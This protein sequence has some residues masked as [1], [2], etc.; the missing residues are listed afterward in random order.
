MSKRN[1]EGGED[2]SLFPFLSVLA[3]VIGTLTMI[4]AAIAVQAL[5]N[6]T[7]E[8]AIEYQQKEEA[9]KEQNLELEKLRSELKKK[10]AEIKATQSEE[11]KR[12]QDAKKRLAE[13]LAQLEKTQAELQNI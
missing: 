5:D 8:T 10:E 2:I 9:L 4:I 7:V 6:D 1:Q 11:Q 13:L 12:L 3:C